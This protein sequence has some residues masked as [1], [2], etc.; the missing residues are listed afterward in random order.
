M[1]FCF[2]RHAGLSLLWPLPLWS[3][4]SRRAGPAAMDHGPSRSA[5]RGILP[6]RGTNPH[7]LHRQADS[8]PLRHQGSPTLSHFKMCGYFLIASSQIMRSIRLSL[9][10]LIITVSSEP[11]LCLAYGRYLNIYLATKE[12]G[13]KAGKGPTLEEDECQFL[14][15]FSYHLYLQIMLT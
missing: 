10:V 3:T 2:L 5:A 13:V 11:K 12:M 1:F 6:D 15:R 7:P 9:S 4:G 14:K 8:Q